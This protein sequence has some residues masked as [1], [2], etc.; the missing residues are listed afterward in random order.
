MRL[1]YLGTPRAS[2]APLRALCAAGH[3]VALVI[4]QPDRKRGRG[5]A[6]V[7]S[8]V[9]LA[10]TDLGLPVSHDLRDS[11]NVGASVGVVV[12]YGA[13]VPADV[14]SALPMLNLH[15]S[16][17]PRWRGAA[18]VER[19][20]LAG[21]VATGVCVMGLEVTLDTGPIF[22][23]R[24]VDIEGRYAGEL[25]DHLSDVG[26]ELLTDTLSSPSLPP[27]VPQVGDATYAKKLSADD[28]LLAPTETADMLHRR[29]RLDRAFTWVH[30]RR[31]R[32]IRAHTDPGTTAPGRVVS[33]NGVVALGAVD[34]S[35]VLDVVQSEGGRAVDADAWW[36]GAR[37]ASGVE[38]GPVEVPRP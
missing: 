12:A 18:P 10:A 2:V 20:I 4:T 35:L 15:F 9:K 23:R 8:P 28:F 19:A 29:V 13:L 21:D 3:D 38:W 32:V 36:S 22:A 11:L 1:L 5:S 6:L 17:L 30:G 27:A 16:S 34:G 33:S 25:T 14:L 24:E 26:A 37:L 7:P 31:L